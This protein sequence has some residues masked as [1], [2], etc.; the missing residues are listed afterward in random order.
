MMKNKITGRTE[1][2]ALV[3]NPVEHSKSPEMY[4]YTFDQLD[5]DCRYV[6]LTA[7]EADMEHTFKA[8][9]T[10]G[11]KGGN[12]TMPVKSIG[13]ELVDKLTDS[14][15]LIG[16][17]NTFRIDDGIIYGH[18]TDG[19]GFI[20]NLR[21]NGHEVKGSKVVLLGTGAAA[22]AIAVQAMLDGVAELTLFNAKD[23]F[24]VNGEK[25]VEKLAK[26][27][28]DRSIA[29]HPLD[30]E[31][32][33]ADKVKGSDFLFNA[34]KVGMVPLED[35]SLIKDTSLYHSDLVVADTIYNPIETKMI[36]EARAANVRAVYGGIGM[37]LYQ[38]A[39]GFNFMTGKEMPVDD[40]K[41]EIYGL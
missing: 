35:Q 6:A 40:V 41:R 13:V 17:V 38:G 29:I 39:A 27:F 32:L 9:R 34:T 30:E 5:M 4:N 14:A 1:L 18:N 3:G 21:A 33:L 7:E 10:L 12:L 26:E 15:R 22:T 24:Y 11:I 2:Y 23:K 8:F 20:D 37:L 36:Q 28:P 25:L 19:K 31:N 16:A